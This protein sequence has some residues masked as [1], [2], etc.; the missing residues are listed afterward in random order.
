MRQKNIILALAALLAFTFT[1]NAQTKRKPT[2][3]KPTRQP[4]T[5]TLVR[6]PYT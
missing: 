6:W 3:S 4:I 2:S 1:A 5:V